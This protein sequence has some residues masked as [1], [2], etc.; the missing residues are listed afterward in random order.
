MENGNDFRDQLKKGFAEFIDRQRAR[1][2]EAETLRVDLHCHDRN[3]DV[4][5]ELLGRLLRIP[6]TWTTSKEVLHALAEAGTDV[7][8]ITNHNNARSCWEL[9]DRGV[10]ILPGAEF[11]CR[12]PDLEAGLHVLAY[13][14]SPAQEVELL[15]RRRDLL[16]FLE[17]AAERE[18]PTVLAHPLFF[19]TEG[20]VPSLA[21]V[22]RLTMLFDNFEVINGQRD[23]WQNLLMAS[24][25][26]DLDEERIERLSRRT[27]IAPATFCRRPFRKGMTGGSDCHM[28]LFAGSTGTLFHVPDLAARRRST[29]GS[30][31]VLDALRQGEFTPYGSYAGAEKLTASFVDYFC[32][33]VLHLEDPG[34]V[35]MLLHKGSADQKLLA[36]AILNGVF[37]LRRHKYTMRFLATAHDAL[38]GKRPGYLLR[39]ITRRDYQ[40][41]LGELDLV[42]RS[43]REGAPEFQRQLSSSLPALFRILGDLLAERVTGKMQ[44]LPPMTAT[45][46]LDAVRGLELPLGLRSMLGESG[47][48]RGGGKARCTD[49]MDG[50]P[51]P[52]LAAIVLQGASFTSAKVMF[53]NRPL[54]NDFATATGRHVH[55][56][57][58]LWLTD[59]FY[60]KNGIATSLQLVHREACERDLPIDFAVVHGEARSG[61]HLHVLKPIAE[62]VVPFYREQPI[63]AF[64]L[65]ELHQIF[66][67]GGYD[68][69]VCSTELG[70]GLAALYLKKAFTVPAHFF[71]HTDWI[72]FCRRTMGF[73]EQDTDRVRRMLRAFYGAFDGLL[74]LN[75][76][77]RD[78]LASPAMG[79]PPGRIRATA[80]WVSEELAASAAE[81]PIS[82]RGTRPPT[83]LYAGRLS[84]EKGVLELPRLYASVRERVPDLRMVIA[85]VGPAMGALQAAMPEATFHGWVSGD[86][87][88]EVYRAADLLVLPSR[89]D[90]FGNVVLEA[91]TCGLPVVAYDTKGPRDI[92]VHGDCGLLASTAEELAAHAEEIL[93]TPRLLAEMQAGALRRAAFYD[94]ERILSDLV[95]DL[96]LLDQPLPL[97]QKRRV[98]TRR[99][100]SPTAQQKSA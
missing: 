98:E 80:H 25:I 72:D 92:V 60:D 96:G 54:L 52:L 43:R 7:L 81:P 5:D 55:P 37:E 67:E 9:Q 71:L 66:A 64:D 50:L 70:M 27:G 90:T 100:T 36:A 44:N 33:A 49:W 45:T 42:A 11:S 83:L 24:W 14:F 91:L 39:K 35:R 16:R 94:K 41:L 4:P 48:Q 97:S 12:L 86:R 15:S 84:E 75:G 3:S 26:E 95:A 73:D 18:L 63:R 8:T 10:D 21:V 40:P 17:Y 65:A 76:E 22:E 38:H 19:H 77:Q 93:S 61:D 69:V 58:A 51:F 34:L 13:G 88:S 59:T 47:G 56:R 46:A 20:D 68:R 28:G 30:A 31:L 85:G 29:S 2:P 82:E 87:I 57:R 79:I 6:E 32:Q 89:F 53:D 99:A 23:A 74:V 62:F 1:F 78:W